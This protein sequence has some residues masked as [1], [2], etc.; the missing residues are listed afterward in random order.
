MACTSS[1][2]EAGDAAMDITVLSIGGQAPAVLSLHPEAALADLR[3]AVSEAFS[4]G[5]L[6]FTLI[7]ENGSKWRQGEYVC[8]RLPRL[9]R[10]D[11]Y[12]AS[13]RTEL[14][15]MRITSTARPARAQSAFFVC[16]TALISKP[17]GHH[18]LDSRR[19]WLSWMGD[20]W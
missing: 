14:Q 6:A 5:Q 18:V 12:L 15:C 19:A 20:C 10:S 7:T 4:V 16:Q 11:D 2:N 8:L 3:A 17:S 9:L 13:L 1:A